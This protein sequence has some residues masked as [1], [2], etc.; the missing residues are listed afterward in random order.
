VTVAHQPLTSIVGEPVG[1]ALKK[2]GHLR[3]DSLGQKRAGT[4]TQ[5]FSQRVAK[6]AWLGKLET[7][8]SVTAYHSF[9]GEV[10]ARNTPTIPRPTLSCRRQL[11]RI[12]PAWYPSGFYRY[13]S[14]RG[15]EDT[16]TV[17]NGSADLGEIVGP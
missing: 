17:G 16:G 2:P 10:E 11:L 13:S 15:V 12:A 6:R 3:C 9:S 5:H 14:E 8:L 7:L 4:A 1:V